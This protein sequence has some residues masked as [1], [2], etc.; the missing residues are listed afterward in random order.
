MHKKK[1]MS[2]NASNE[3]EIEV[4]EGKLAIY[5]DWLNIIP[6]GLIKA[7]RG[8]LSPKEKGAVT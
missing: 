4:I 2:S 1:K 5:T 7:S 8:G 6:I 3:A